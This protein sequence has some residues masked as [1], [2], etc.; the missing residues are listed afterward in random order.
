MSKTNIIEKMKETPLIFDGAMGTM[1]YQ[2]G[3]FVNTCY[4]QLNLINPN[5]IKN[6]H[7]KYFEAGADVLLTNTFG[8]N[9]IKLKA[10][11]ISDLVEKINTEAV[12]LAQEV[13]DENTYIVGCVGPCTKK[14]QLITEENKKELENAFYEQINALKNA[15][16]DAIILETFSNIDELLIAS[17]IA[18]KQNLPVIASC[19]VTK[20]GENYQGQSLKKI[21]K[22]LE[23]NSNIDAI[24]INC[25]IGPVA[26][27][28]LV[29]KNIQYTTKPLVI[30]PNAGL[31]QEVDGR[32]IYMSTPEY[33]TTY[34]KYYISLGCRAVGG[35]CGTTPE[36]IKDMAMAIKALSH[37]KQKTNLNKIET[38]EIDIEPIAQADK[39]QL[40]KKLSE[41]KKVTSIE[42]TPPRSV[43]L[44][45]IIQKAQK[46]KD[47]GI[48]AINIPDGPRASSRISPMIT[49]LTIEQKVGIETVLH[50]CCRDRNL[51]GMQSDLL[52]SYAAGLKNCL[53]VTGDAPKMGDYPDATA[54]FDLDSVGL[55][56]VVHN[57]NLGKDIG[58]NTINP[59][60]GIFI[61]VGA[62]PCAIDLNKEIEHYNNKLK[63]GA[64]F[65]ITQPIFD[66]DALLFFLDKI[67][68]LEKQIPVIAGVWPLVSY[69]NASFLK[70]EVP[71]VVVPD[72]ILEKMSKAQTK[73]DGIKIGIEIAQ[74]IIEKISKDVAGFQISAP[75]G[76]V[77]IAIEVLK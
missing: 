28:S 7:K 73:E 64:E 56:K 35:C 29:E 8:A 44:D 75:F 25:T 48:D 60:T 24:G 52:G 41:G 23:Q 5:L 76:K 20:D 67:N 18:K 37:T 58:G 21:L 2:Q 57:L 65:A 1:I 51:I 63:A 3:I 6:I 32:M 69:K 39:S 77:D 14:N 72:I 47:F 34:A 16:I 70:T 31:P 49:A 13:S 54:V 45:D 55:T 38:I 12:K 22:K 15:G 74:N 30:Q 10:H 66:A 40:A 11:G 27:L 59:P 62:N 43:L 17:E 4:D 33:F 71:G 68:K 19:T 61:G 46:C 53:I 42:I 36:H 26:M 50:Y 9:R